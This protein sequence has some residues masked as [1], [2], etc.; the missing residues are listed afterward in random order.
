MND[1][2]I[3]EIKD[4]LAALN[5]AIAQT[6][7]ALRAATTPDD[8]RSL[9]SRL[10]DLRSERSRLETELNNLEAAGIEIREIGAGETKVFRGGG[11]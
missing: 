8:T 9:S 5:D 3:N 2:R 1:D 11:T 10:V 6:E 4:G 7:A